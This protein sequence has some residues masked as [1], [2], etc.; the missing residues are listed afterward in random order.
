MEKIYF[1][2]V[3]DAGL[4]PLPVPPR[5]TSLKNL[6]NGLPVGVYSALRTFAHHKF[7]GLD[8]HIA[9]TQRSMG[10][11]GWDYEFDEAGLRQGLHTACLNFPG[12]EARVR[13]DVL[14]EPAAQLGTDSRVLIALLPL[15]TVPDYYYTEGVGAEFAP[16]LHRQRPLAKTADF[17]QERESYKPGHTQEKYEYLIQDEQGY[18]LEGSGTNFWG[19][20][21]G[22]VWTADEGVLEGVTRKIILSLLPD[23]GIPLRLEAIHKDDVQHLDEAAISG[24]SRAFL[25]V[26]KIGG[27]QIGHGRSGPISQRILSAYNQYLKRAIKTAIQV[28]I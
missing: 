2:A 14:A 13:F 23:L 9:R 19:I 11:L 7:L 12:A 4:R 3:T 17:A 28:E 18:I 1:Y 16:L 26:V 8:D 10:V 27:R 21:D 25:P 20:R 24:S 6:Y 15:T 5:T 22:A